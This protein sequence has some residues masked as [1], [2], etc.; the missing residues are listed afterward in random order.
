MIMI[1]F[2][3]LKSLY[4]LGKITEVHL[5]NA[6]AKGWITEEQKNLILGL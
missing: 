6:V 4:D 5:S 2:D 3:Y 1:I